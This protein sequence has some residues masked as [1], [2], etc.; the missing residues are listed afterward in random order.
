M[1]DLLHQYAAEKLHQDPDVE[2]RI[3]IRHTAY[4]TTFLESQITALKGEGWQ[5]AKTAVAAEI[6]N[7][8]AAWRWALSHTSLHELSQAADSLA[9]FYDISGWFQEGTTPSKRRQRCYRN[10]SMRRQR[11]RELNRGSASCVR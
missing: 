1:H 6:D 5:E 10:T 7:I 9:H 3:L 11:K 4:Y 8:R 2:R